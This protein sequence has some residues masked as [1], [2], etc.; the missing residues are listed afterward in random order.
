[1]KG[2]A[3]NTITEEVDRIRVVDPAE[4]VEIVLREP[5]TSGY[6]WHFADDVDHVVVLSNRLSK[7]RNAFGG[8]A[9]RSFVVRF[10]QDVPPRLVFNLSRPWE[11]EPVRS[12]VFELDRL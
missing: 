2:D 1:M 3:M 11:D 7:N 6:V 10:G 4:P 5:A 9:R 12:K 8:A